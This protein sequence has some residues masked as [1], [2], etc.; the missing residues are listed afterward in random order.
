MGAYFFPTILKYACFIRFVKPNVNIIY[1]ITTYCVVCYYKVDVLH[2]FYCYRSGRATGIGV[3][4]YCSFVSA[5]V[6]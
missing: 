4:A 6:F 5:I 3:W 1:N 2:Q